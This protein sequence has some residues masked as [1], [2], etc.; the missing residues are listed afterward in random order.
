MKPFLFLILFLC[1]SF[2][3]FCGSVDTVSIFSTSMQKQIKC[4]V[5]KPSNYKKRK[6]FAVVYL[7]HGHSGNYSNW[8]I[9]VPQL[10]KY[11][12]DFE[13]LI[14][15]P[16]GA[17]SSWYFDSPIDTTYRYETHIATELVN[18]IDSHYKTNPSPQKRAITGLSMGGHG[19]L[20]LAL[21][22]STIFGAAGSMSGGVDLNESKNKF[23]IAK[24]IGDTILYANNWH[25]FTVVNLIENYTTSNQKIIFD[26]GISDFFI[27]G[28]R[29][30]HQKMVALKI[31]HT[32]IEREGEH[33]WAYWQNAVQY[34][35][36][37]FKNY[38][39]KYEGN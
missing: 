6:N 2:Y 27:K 29:L 15:C 37:F 12:D 36:L 10:K 17:Y 32:Y 35:L 26:C 19:A 20:F 21:K 33:N 7:L 24:R 34:Q 18:Y 25:N 23:D 22:H 8:I 4:V 38:F 1:T 28:N 39:K 11:A 5:I 31:P 30:L 13:L 3:A 14:V 16:D 9:K